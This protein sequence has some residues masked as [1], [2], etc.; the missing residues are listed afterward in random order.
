[1]AAYTE[2]LKAITQKEDEKDMHTHFGDYIAARTRAMT[3]ERATEVHGKIIAI[4]NE[5]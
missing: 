1:M 4:L 3:Q 5:Y 2:A